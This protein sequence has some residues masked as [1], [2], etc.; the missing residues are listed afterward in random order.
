M[1]K[2]E[3]QRLH[4]HRHHSL[5]IQRKGKGAPDVRMSESCN[6]GIIGVTRDL[7]RAEMVG[8]ICEEHPLVLCFKGKEDF[9]CKMMDLPVAE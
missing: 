1:V 8:A 5:D 9:Q 6:I 7:E 2:T 3:P 4:L